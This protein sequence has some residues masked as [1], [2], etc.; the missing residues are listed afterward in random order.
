MFNRRGFL[1][2]SLSG[3]GAFALVSRKAYSKDV[4]FPSYSKEIERIST[5]L[6]KTV[7]PDIRFDQLFSLRGI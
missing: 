6:K 4:S 5:V 2:I 1:I 7:S 3:L